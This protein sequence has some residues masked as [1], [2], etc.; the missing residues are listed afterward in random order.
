MSGL[1]VCTYV[2][3]YV[4]TSMYVGMS[5]M[6]LFIVIAI[7]HSSHTIPQSYSTHR[8]H[9]FCPC[10]RSNF[11]EEAVTK[12]VTL[13]RG[14]YKASMWRFQD[15][16]LVVVIGVWLPWVG[17]T[18]LS[19]M[20]VPYKETP[21]LLEPNQSPRLRLFDAWLQRNL[22]QRKETGNGKSW[23]RSL[24]FSRW[25]DFHRKKKH[26]GSRGP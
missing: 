26:Q 8:A 2:R 13:S 12:R 10:R 14:R 3:M 1:Y 11:F 24:S 7:I 18:L 19:E 25:S 21:T 15:R 4:R 20:K 9:L 16:L 17:W 6:L 23:A 22:S 5:R